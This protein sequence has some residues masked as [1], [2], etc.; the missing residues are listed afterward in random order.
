V[1]LATF[2]A[3]LQSIFKFTETE[4]RQKLVSF[5]AHKTNLKLLKFVPASG[6]A[7]ECL[8]FLNTFLNQFDPSSRND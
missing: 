1:S 6:A 2:R 4:F 7:V 8:N 3:P 5:D